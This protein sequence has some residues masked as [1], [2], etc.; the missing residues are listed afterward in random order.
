VAA[1]VE[2]CG[3]LSWCAP[4]ASIPVLYP[5]DQSIVLDEVRRLCTLGAWVTAER[6]ARS[7]SRTDDGADIAVSVRAVLENLVGIGDLEKGPPYAPGS[8]SPREPTVVA[9]RPVPW[10]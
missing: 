2:A 10:K 9:Y 3:T 8:F 7:L 4:V 1:G 6:V 5:I